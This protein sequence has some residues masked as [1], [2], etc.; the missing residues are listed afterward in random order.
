MRVHFPD[1]IKEYSNTNED[2]HTAVEEINTVVSRTEKVFSHLQVDGVDIYENHYQYLLDE[3][4]SIGDIHIVIVDKTQMASELQQ[5]LNEYLDRSIPVMGKLVD[6]FYRGASAEGWDGFSN[7]AEGLQWILGAL[8]TLAQ[9]SDEEAAA[10]Y[11][12]VQEKIASVLEELMDA[13]EAQDTVTIADTI[14]YEIVE[15]LAELKQKVHH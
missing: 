3:A 12:E 2:I 13:I 9:Y 14:Q 5:S 7:L 1:Q 6:S 8:Q 11:T 4:E 15:T 10:Y